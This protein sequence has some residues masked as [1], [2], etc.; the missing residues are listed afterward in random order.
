MQVANDEVVGVGQI[1]QVYDPLLGAKSQ[2]SNLRQINL[3]SIAHAC[4]TDTMTVQLAVKEMI[5]QVKH[6]MKAGQNVRLN[7]KVGLLTSQN[8]VLLWRQAFDEEG[9]AE[10]QSQAAQSQAM[11]NSV[12]RKDLS[13]KTPSV[14]VTSR[15]RT[16]ASQY[17]RSHHMANPNPQN[18]DIKYKGIRDVGYNVALNADAMLQDTIRFG[19]KVNIDK[20]LSND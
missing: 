13:V 8:G 17:S 2:L 4:E 15:S 20:P 7:F 5:A 18:K 19:K 12:F 11:V 16:H 9:M 10:G 6:M 3:A 14:A 1:L